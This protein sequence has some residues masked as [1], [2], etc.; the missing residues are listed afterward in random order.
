MRVVAIVILLVAGVAAA[1]PSVK[2]ELSTA[3]EDVV[4]ID[5]SPPPR[6][7]WS[8]DSVYAAGKMDGVRPNFLASAIKLSNV[9][10]ATSSDGKSA[11][12][13]ADAKGVPQS[14]D[15]APGPCA[16]NRAPPLHVTAVF[17]RGT[18]DW[19]WVAWHIAEPVDAKS[20]AYLNKEKTAPDKLERAITG[21]EEAVKVFEASLVDSKSL[22]ATVSARKDVVL[23]GSDAKERTVGG[24]KVKAK[25][26]AWNLTFKLRDGVQAGVTASKN[27]AW[28]AAN[29][30]A[31]SA[32]KPKDPASP[33]RVLAIYEQQADKSWKL[34]SLQ[35]SVDKG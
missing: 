13:A 33:Y 15:C 34:V 30:D 28:V 9:V 35:F 26:A 20:Q 27:I 19:A 4:Q 6:F 16:P 3:L 12:L 14:G 11:W 10:V 2:E 18:K 25:L 29:V 23:Y 5:P 1:A 32:K 7:A 31:T 21:A 22:G 17:E 24:P 8:N